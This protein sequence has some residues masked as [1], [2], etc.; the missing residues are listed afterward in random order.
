M[1]RLMPLILF[2]LLISLACQAVQL[3]SAPTEAAVQVKTAPEATDTPQAPTQAAPSPTDTRLATPTLAPTATGIAHAMAT[4]TP[5]PTRSASPTSPAPT[6]SATSPV[7]VPTPALPT[8]CQPIAHYSDDLI[9]FEFPLPRFALSGD[10]SRLVFTYQDDDLVAGDSNG[11]GDV[12]LFDANRGTTTLVSVS[13]SGEQQNLPHYDDPRRNPGHGVAI[14]ADGR[15]V[16]FTS[17]AVN[18]VPGLNLR[19]NTSHLYLRDLANGTTS[20]ISRDASGE[21]LRTGAHLPSISADG[22]YI[23]FLSADDFKLYIYDRTSDTAHQISLTATGEDPDE[24]M[25]AVV[26]SADGQ[27]IAYT[28]D[29]GNIVSGDD[30][31]TYDL[32]VKDLTTDEIVRVSVVPAGATIET[33][34]MLPPSLSAD[35]SVVAFSA[36][37]FVGFYDPSLTG[38]GYIFVYDA[39]SGQVSPTAFTLGGLPLQI[40]MPERMGAPQLTADGRQAIFVSSF[41]NP[42]LDLWTE[43]DAL[44]HNFQTGETALAA[45]DWDGTSVTYGHTWAA[46]I[47]PDGSTV[48]LLT[49]SYIPA[50]GLEPMQL[51]LCTWP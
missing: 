1:R 50:A 7:L 43:S 3:P 26:L 16:A 34:F 13:S 9:R 47:S 33:A 38:G 44:I 30:N 6:A 42:V 22:R 25:Y 48:A 40:S 19:E 15:F 41:I 37:S 12:F 23:A 2:V 4:R 49:D 11:S 36:V 27:H 20:L 39:A 21:P 18:L 31:A 14:S 17:Q 10:G 51:M 45:L 8:A 35:G 5:S 28:T 46:T 32:F 24:W 29:A